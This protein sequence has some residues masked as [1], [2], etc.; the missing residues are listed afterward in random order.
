MDIKY[1]INA[2]LI[3]DLPTDKVEPSHDEL[4]MMDMLFKNTSTSSMNNLFKELKDS[5]I[6]AILFIVFS[7]PQIDSLLN[8]YIP[9]TQTSLYILIL[10][11]SIFVMGLYWLIKHFYLATK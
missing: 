3:K 11:K 6:V 7:I 1:A 8:K 2:D 4:Q 10:I 5:L 9:I